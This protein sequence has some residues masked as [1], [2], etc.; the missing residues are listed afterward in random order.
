[1]ATL[2]VVCALGT[3]R[4][5]QK[6]LDFNLTFASSKTPFTI[7]GACGSKAA[8]SAAADKFDCICVVKMDPHDP[9]AHHPKYV[10]IRELGQGA[11]FL[12]W[13]QLFFGFTAFTTPD[14]FTSGTFGSVL[15]ARN[16]QSGKSFM[17]SFRLCKKCPLHEYFSPPPSLTPCSHTTLLQIQTQS[18]TITICRRRRC[19]KID[20]PR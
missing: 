17:S 1:M 5:A 15:H 10:K 16:R 14:H 18:Q 19:C 13:S 6:E 8:S 3:G 20:R 12:D 2:L 7:P 11:H 9:L 4:I